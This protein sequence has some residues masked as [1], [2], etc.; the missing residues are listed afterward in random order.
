MIKNIFFSLL[1][2][3]GLALTACSSDDNSVEQAPKIYYMTVDATKGVNEA[4]S[5]AYRRAL[6][7]SGSTLSASWATTEHVY[8]QGTLV[9]NSTLFWFEGSI[10]P[11]TAGTTTRLNGAISL[12]AGWQYSSIDEAIGTPYRVNLQFPRSGVLD[13]TGQIGTLAD[14]AAKYDYA[15]ATNVQ[16]DIENDHIVGTN[17]A[18]F[19]NQQAIVKFTLIDKADGTT[20]LNPTALTIDNGLGDDYP[21][22]LTIPAATYTTNGDGVLYVAIPGFSGQNVTL[23]AT[24]SSGTYNY[25]KSNVTFTNGKYYEI[26]VK[27]T[28]QQ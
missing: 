16:F 22:T 4:A 19:F 9:S 14:I 7:L 13:Y 25:T 21:L 26:T 23:T 17:S 3:A 8:V 27:M 6:N 12:P 2:I 5:P 24:C 10:Q 11:Q 18:T 15:I 1:L 20:K 28:K